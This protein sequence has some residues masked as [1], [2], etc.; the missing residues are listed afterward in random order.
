MILCYIF[1]LLLSF[2]TDQMQTS[3]ISK[4]VTLSLNL[5]LLLCH[6]LFG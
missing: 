6:T 2:M 1:F 3:V 4:C 5:T